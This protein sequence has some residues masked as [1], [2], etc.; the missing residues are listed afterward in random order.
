MISVLF[1]ITEAIVAD[2]S[3]TPGAMDDW[4]IQDPFCGSKVAISYHT[5]L[6]QMLYIP[7]VQ[8]A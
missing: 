8:W 5:E 1:G 6:S 2:F 4:L 7:A 3:E